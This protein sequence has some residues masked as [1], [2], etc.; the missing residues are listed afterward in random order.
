[1]CLAFNSSDNS[2]LVGLNFQPS[3]NSRKTGY[4]LPSLT[5]SLHGTFQLRYLT[6]SRVSVAAIQPSADDCVYTGH[7]LGVT[8]TY[9]VCVAAKE[10]AC[11]HG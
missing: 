11:M 1:M 8:L 7:P 3:L 6:P 10:R 2:T 9:H 5:K 4:S